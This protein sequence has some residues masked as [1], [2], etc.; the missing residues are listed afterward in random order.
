MQKV[1]QSRPVSRPSTSIEIPFYPAFSI[2]K[3]H[4]GVT[5]YWFE[6]DFSQV[7]YGKRPERGRNAC[8]LIALLTASKLAQHLKVAATTEKEEA[9]VNYMMIKC[10]AEGILQ[11]IQEYSVLMEQNK[12]TNMNL[13]VPEAYKALAGNVANIHEWV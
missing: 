8:V 3:R 9:R 10:F 6:K 7:S 4:D 11:G 12:L 13:T 2:E 1:S 5:V